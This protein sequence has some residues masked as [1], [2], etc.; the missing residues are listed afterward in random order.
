MMSSCVPC[1]RLQ[2]GVD[3]VEN[4]LCF[5]V[6]ASSVSDGVV[7]KAEGVPSGRGKKADPLLLE[8]RLSLTASTAAEVEEWIEALASA[9]LRVR[10]WPAGDPKSYMRHVIV[11]GTLHAMALAGDAFALLGI[12]HP[13][14][15]SP[16]QQHSAGT[17]TLAA[18]CAVDALGRSALHCAA[19]AGHLQCLRLLLDAGADAGL[20]DDVA[21]ET[22]LHAA[23]SAT[24][25]GASPK[26][27]GSAAAVARLLLAS[28]SRLDASACNQMGQSPLE[29]A[30]TSGH[31]DRETAA[32][33][34]TLCP[35]GADASDA[36]KFLVARSDASSPPAPA[37]AAATTGRSSNESPSYQL[38]LGPLT[39]KALLRHGAKP[40]LPVTNDSDPSTRALSPVEQLLQI[41]L[42]NPPFEVVGV[43][44]DGKTTTNE[45]GPNGEDEEG[46]ASSEFV[47]EC[48]EALAGAGARLPPPSASTAS[49]AASST[50]GSSLQK[51]SDTLQGPALNKVIQAYDVWTADNSAA[52]RGTVMAHKAGCVALVNVLP[53]SY[54][55]LCQRICQC[56]VLS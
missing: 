32:L 45:V 37:A 15:A 38:A 22:P 29:V 1:D 39:L 23:C 6:A 40:N 9:S 20:A 16:V 7:E 52:R 2:V 4:P 49:S 48:L 42:Q 43:K 54:R 19:A 10:P 46:T 51:W 41:L 50:K 17:S 31:T 26:A 8:D 36:L 3:E 14:D 21:L 53:L 44:A 47:W 5:W 30:L 12:L 34:A 18:A 13:G 55:M 35:A 24:A 33:V 11:Q 27:P 25:S 56:V 28:G